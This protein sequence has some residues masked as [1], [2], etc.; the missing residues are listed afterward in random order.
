MYDTDA[1]I[2]DLTAIAHAAEAIPL[3]QSEPR[4]TMVAR[5][6]IQ[7]SPCTGDPGVGPTPLLREGRPENSRHMRTRLAPDQGTSRQGV[8]DRHPRDDLKAP[9][10]AGQSRQLPRRDQD[11]VHGQLAVSGNVFGALAGTTYL[12]NAGSTS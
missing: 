4:A 11:A 3:K 10:W 8:A 7:A 6:R 1:V 9:Q 2:D 5:C 12:A